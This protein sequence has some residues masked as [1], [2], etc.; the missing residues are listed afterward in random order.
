MSL[1]SRRTFLVGGGLA[2]ASYLVYEVETIR[3]VRYTVPVSNLPPAFEGFTILHLS[4][5]HQKEFGTRQKRLLEL[6][7]HQRFD[8]VAITGD[9]LIQQHPDVQPALDLLKGLPPVPIFFVNGNNEWGAVWQKKYTI[10]RRLGTAGAMVLANR[11]V[12]VSRGGDHVWIAGVDDPT[13]QLDRLDRAMA[14]A[15]DGATVI[16]LAHSPAIFSKAVRAGV[17]LLLSGHTHGGQIRLP[18]V[19]AIWGPG[20]GLF[21]AWDYGEFRKGMTTMIVNGGLGESIIPVR[22]NMQPEI[23]LVTLVREQG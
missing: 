14:G 13:N 15:D 9:L 17:N 11:S 5:L 1:I 2:L 3:V 6:I 23:V 21:P 12:P 16:L 8:V 18:A 22:I 10:T 4:D 19:G 20:L 7:G